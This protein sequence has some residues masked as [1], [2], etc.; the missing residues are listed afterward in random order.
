MLSLSSND[1]IIFLSK[2]FSVDPAFI[3]QKS[4]DNGIIS[5]SDTE[6][7][8]ISTLSSLL[9]YQRRLLEPL[10]IA[11]TKSSPFD[12]IVSLLAYKDFD[13]HISL[14]IAD[15]SNIFKLILFK[16]ELDSPRFNINS[17]YKIDSCYFKEG[18]LLTNNTPK[19]I[20]FYNFDHIFTIRDYYLDNLP[21][22]IY[23]EE[24]TK[25]TSL[26][27]IIG[28][29]YVSIVN[30][31]TFCF[32][33][34]KQLQIRLI[35]FKLEDLN[36]SYSTKLVRISYCELDYGPDAY[37]LKM[38]EFSVFTSLSNFSFDLSTDQFKSLIRFEYP[39]TRMSLSELTEKVVACTKI[40]LVNVDK[41]DSN[42]YFF[43]YD[44][45]QAVIF[46]VFDDIFAEQL[47]SL[48]TD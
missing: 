29:F 25:I 4:I 44:S 28:Y 37:Q 20:W 22:C 43:G 27:N 11:L 8:I 32:I 16:K 2:Y 18:K 47:A 15:R 45:S 38:S 26:V 14:L 39:S 33:H 48:I 31:K 41:N 23:D 35:P 30:D 42:W 6:N 19:E 40:K 34:S 10:S 1:F 17:T 12:S 21:E 9:G 7:A 24:Y 3:I 13:K 5:T 46:T 36:Q